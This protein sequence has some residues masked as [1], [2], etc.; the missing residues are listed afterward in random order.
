VQCKVANVTRDADGFIVWD[1]AGQM[2]GRVRRLVVAVGHGPVNKPE[3]LRAFRERA[4]DDVRV[5][6]SFEDKKYEANLAYVVV[7]DGLTAA[8]EWMNILD[9][10]GTVLAISRRGFT[11]GQSLNTPRKYFSRRGLETY[12]AGSTES[13]R[14]ELSEATKGTV[15]GYYWRDQFAA[16]QKEGRLHLLVGDVE[17]VEV[18]EAGIDVTLASESGVGSLHA[19]R[20][21]CATGFLPAAAHMLWKKVIAE[22]KLS[23][24]D[25]TS[26]LRLDEHMQ[27]VDGLYVV[28][29][30]AAWVLPN[31]DSL[32]GM[33][34]AAR[35][36]AR[37]VVPTSRPTLAM[38][39][40]MQIVQH[41]ELA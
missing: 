35:R 40:W 15:P 9:Q 22:W 24:D 28:G 37:H 41:R 25:V 33:K 5:R 3:F 11:I 39:S 21:L 26:H 19:D 36:I 38:R 7:G 29:S 20:L 16:A 30:A 13:R 18:H 6:H 17:E 4:G 27:V 12:V 32:T 10:G 34:I 23:Q 31:A 1:E 14:S 8:T 2:R